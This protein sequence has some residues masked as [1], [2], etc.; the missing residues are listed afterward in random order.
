MKSVLN[1]QITPLRLALGVMLVAALAWATGVIPIDYNER[2]VKGGG[3][4]VGPTYS[5]GTIGTTGT[6]N[7]ITSIIGCE[8]DEDF[9]V[10]PG[11]HT[12][13]N[14]NPCTC[15]GVKM[16]DPCFAGVLATSPSDGGSSWQVGLQIEAVARANNLVEIDITNGV[17][18][19]TWNPTDAG[20]LIRCIS[21]Q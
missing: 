8:C 16:G 20:Y 5:V 7:R 3:L 14:P 21:S 4:T 9:P 11:T 6:S 18:A 19:G 10:I 13:I 1:L 17:D 2:W 15:T 12:M